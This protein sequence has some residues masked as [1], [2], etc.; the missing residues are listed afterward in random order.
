MSNQEKQKKILMGYFLLAA[1]EA[2]LGIIYL[3]SIPSDPK[4]QWL[5]GYSLS[6]LIFLAGFLVPLLFMSV[7]ALHVWRDK[8]WRNRIWGSILPKFRANLLGLSG[9]SLLLTIP[10][11]LTPL[12]RFG[13]WQPYIERLFPFIWYII[14]LSL[15]TI[16][17]LN[18]QREYMAWQDFANEIK[19]N[20]LAL[21]F[22]I[23][24]LFGLILL[25][26]G[27]TF[28]GIGIRGNWGLWREAG[29]PLLPSQILSTL[30]IIVAWQIITP[31]VLRNKAIS[32]SPFSDWVCQRKDVLISVGIWLLT[33][34]LWTSPL[35]RESFFFP[36]PYP[37]SNE[38]YPFA[39]SATWNM[40]GQFALIG[41][42]FANR[43][44]FA[45]HVGL[46]G[47]EAILHLL[48]GQNYTQ[49]VVAQTALYA[50]FP[51]ILYWLGKHFHSTS[52]GTLLASLIILRE[53]NAFASGNMINL[54]HAKFLLTE[55]PVGI[56]LAAITLWFFLWLRKHPQKNIAYALPI[57]GVL[58]ILILLRFNTLG[59]P[60]AILAGII[61]YFGRNWKNTF[62]SSLLILIS[63]TIVLSPWMWR[64]WK[65]AETP[66][67]F[68]GKASAILNEKFRAPPAPAP[69]VVPPSSFEKAPNA[70]EYLSIGYSIDKRAYTKPSPVF[71]E[72][73]PST[74]LTILN[75]FVHNLV[76]SVLILPT[77]PF[78]HNLKHTLY[79]VS[80]FWNKTN[81]QWAGDL[82]TLEGLGLLL[83]LV[84]LSIGI[85]ISWQKWRL[86]GLIPLGIYIAYNF[87]TALA[88]TS[89]GRYI[90]PI[91]WVVLFYFSL[92]VIQIIFWAGVLPQRKMEKWHPCYSSQKEPKP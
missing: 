4:N 91:S 30:I 40:Y 51:V 60:L 35:L 1:V 9:F 81:G 15:Q 3:L 6:R 69:T 42:G 71:E 36:G 27:I 48:I 20:R 70:K 24:T 21:L 74:S 67:F 43:S 25:W 26:G 85:G 89:G 32:T 55:F 13:D 75:H 50:I 84:L 72:T 19:K 44:A 46:A 79:E 29:V 16:I 54:S 7:F 12:Y 38:F 2:C 59:I 33:F 28:T 78:F 65:I 53:M 86:P 88:R 45:D 83:N 23:I 76:T 8:I 63:I 31:I 22:S 92:G 82:T 77:T 52:A 14:F 18:Y 37:P 57:G 64:S 66:F 62:K 68:S 90:V 41:Q 47:F 11:L 17:S 34:L 10:I 39:D 87:S 61:L 58:A 49:L 56:G 73:R 5:W 80:P